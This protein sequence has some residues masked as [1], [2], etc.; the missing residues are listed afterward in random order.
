MR[1]LVTGGAGFIGSHVVEQLVAE[2]C[3][4]SVI[5]NLS[6]GREGNLSK[7]AH[8][9]KVDLNDPVAVE[10]TVSNVK[11]D[12]VLH[13]AAQKSVALSVEK[14]LLD[15]QENII[16]SLH[17]FEAARAH[18]VRKIVF[19]STGGAL[20]GDD[21]PLP[22]PE[23]HPTFPESPYGIAKLAIE[24]YLRFYTKV[25]GIQAVT[26]R[27]ANVYGPRQD[28]QGEAGVVAIFCSRG[29][30]NEPV[31]IFA[32]GLQTREYT[33]VRDFARAFAIALKTSE[34]LTVNIGTAVQPSVVGL[35]AAIQLL[36]GAHVLRDFHEGRVGEI[37]HSCLAIREAQARLGWQPKFGLHE[38]L[39]ETVQFFK[40]TA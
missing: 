5:D 21:A 22:T 10:S 40:G 29:L 36:L 32:D 23:D 2:G 18:G 28:P 20:Y 13:L 39:A 12:A 24:H 35:A 25:H 4:V 38:G 16:A 34:S 27:M 17:L 30:S 33:Y 19:A 7:G 11:P 14:P 15:A 31:S 9:H 1:V 26:L 6:T 8:L 37:R 3:D